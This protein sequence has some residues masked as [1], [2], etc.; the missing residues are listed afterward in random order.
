MIQLK[1]L[2]LWFITV[3][4]IVGIVINTYQRPARPRHYPD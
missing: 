1:R 2:R 3:L 4:H